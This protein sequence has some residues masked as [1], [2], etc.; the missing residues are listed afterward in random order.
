MK[1]LVLGLLALAVLSGCIVAPG[2]YHEG[3]WDREHARYWHHH[4]WDKP[5][6]GG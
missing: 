5:L 3:Y 6:R 4:R 2:E 1:N